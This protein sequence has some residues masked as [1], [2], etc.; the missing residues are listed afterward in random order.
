MTNESHFGKGAID[1]PEDFLQPL[2][3]RHDEIAGAFQPAVWKEKDPTTGFVTYPK[4][5]QGGQ[6]DCVC[7]AIAK[8]L[9]IDELSEN[10]A[11]RELSPRSLYPYVVVPGGGSSSI[12]ASK[13]AVKQGMTL[14][15]LLPTDG[16]SE[17][18]AEVDK[19]YVT[20]A[21]QIALVYKPNSYI[22]AAADFETI[23]SIL[24]GYQMQGIKK[25]VTITVIGYNNGSWLSQFPKPPASASQPGLWYHRVTVTDFGL[26][27]GVKHLA[28]D[29]SWGESA[30]N[31]GQQLLSIDYQPFIYGAIYTLNQQDNWQQMGISQVEMPKHVWSVDLTLG[32]TGADVTALQTALQ[33][34][35]MFPISSVVK[36]TGYY[37]GITRSAVIVFQ[38]S[39]ALT[40]TG[41]CD[42]PTR[43][44]LNEIFKG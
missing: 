30:G 24:Q 42:A 5:N 7:Y 40:A 16:L 9:A 18:D 11:W 23:A 15:H 8:Q 25:G 10:G 14:E 32:A 26:V 31:K 27:N 38:Q 36:P 21:K 41:I 22:E 44:K 19:G 34:L 33:S 37:G 3:Y 20:D 29:N 39:F 43:G 13:L 1:K 28:I 2:A 12:A 6:S 35:G 4:R 17:A